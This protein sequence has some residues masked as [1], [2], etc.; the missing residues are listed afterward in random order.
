[1]VPYNLMK[2]NGK[3]LDT[4]TWSAGAIK[5]AKPFETVVV[6]SSKEENYN[7]IP[8]G[9]TVPN[10]ANYFHCTSNNTFWNSNKRISVIRHAYCM[11]YEF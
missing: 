10:D 3:H 7:H 9:Y 6:A 4:G 5:E 11:R 8:K 2:E 1:M